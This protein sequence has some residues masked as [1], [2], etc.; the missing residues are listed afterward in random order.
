MHP[1]LGCGHDSVARPVQAVR[2]TGDNA[3]R[4]IRE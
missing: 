2:V 3:A 1:V 4:A